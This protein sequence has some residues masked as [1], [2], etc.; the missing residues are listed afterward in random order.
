LNF[1]RLLPVILSWI[2][3]GAHFMR[4]GHHIVVAGCLLVPFLL[5]VRRPWVPP[6]MQLGLFLGALEWIRVL[7]A[8]S[9]M[10]RGH[11]IPAGRMTLILGGVAL[12]TAA[13][14]LMFLARPLRRRYGFLHSQR[15]P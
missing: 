12:F 3:L 11:G 2:V 5:L 14:A 15:V 9:A 10:R 4:G 8:L 7:M 1:L 6:L 13:S